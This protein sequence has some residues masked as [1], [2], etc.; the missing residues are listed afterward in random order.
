MRVD[1]VHLGESAGPFFFDVQLEQTKTMMGIAWVAKLV[2]A[3]AAM[4][5]CNELRERRILLLFCAGAEP[6]V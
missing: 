2:S 1:Q 4:A 5:A 6:A 3:T